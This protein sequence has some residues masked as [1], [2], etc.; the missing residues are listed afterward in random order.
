[1]EASESPPA[2]HEQLIF[3]ALEWQDMTPDINK[4]HIRS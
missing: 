1:L 4:Q 2:H 3:S